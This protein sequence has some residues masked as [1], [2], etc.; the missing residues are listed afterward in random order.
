ML[1]R[2]WEL[3]HAPLT[4]RAGGMGAQGEF[5]DAVSETEVTHSIISQHQGGYAIYLASGMRKARSEG[6]DIATLTRRAGKPSVP[7]TIAPG[8]TSKT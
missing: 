8:P 6:T 3:G 7:V 1:L 4:G 2:L 5:G